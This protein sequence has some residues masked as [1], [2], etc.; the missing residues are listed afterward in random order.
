M[1]NQREL[2]NNTIIN[3][4]DVPTSGGIITTDGGRPYKQGED[5][6]SIACDGSYEMRVTPGWWLFYNGL[7][8]VLESSVVQITPC[9]QQIISYMPATERTLIV[10]IHKE[11]T[12]IDGTCSWSHMSY[13]QSVEARLPMEVITAGALDKDHISTEVVRSGVRNTLGGVSPSNFFRRAGG[14]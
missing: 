5:P 9:N 10:L 8:E 7:T 3:F 1:G 4:G 2:R 13:V 11:L 12:F 14:R 6:Y